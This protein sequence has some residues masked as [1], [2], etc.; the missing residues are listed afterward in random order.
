M[1]RISRPE[2]APAVLASAN[3]KA[4][5]EA[6]K[7][8]FSADPDAYRSGNKTFAGKGETPRF[9][10]KVYG[11]AG[12]RNALKAM[13]SGKCAFCESR[14]DHVSYGD[15][16]HFRPKGAVRQAAD[17][18]LERPGYYWLVYEWSNL[19]ESCQLCNQRFKENRFPLRDPASRAR[20]H[21]QDVALEKPMLVKPD[22]EDPADFLAFEADI[23]RGIDPVGRGETTIDVLQLNRPE[24]VSRR[25]EH[26]ALLYL[27]ARGARKLPPDD[28]VRIETEARVLEMT[29]DQG[30]YA[31]M[32]RA[33]IAAGW[34]QPQT[35]P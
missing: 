11:A 22:I 31:A 13:Q 23:M 10:S 25:R 7:D 33:A 8:A 16:E 1:I 32:V 28:P 29:R 20:D 2:R 4:R 24:L 30:Q 35:T 14:F 34:N 15:V 26:Y 17:G 21:T 18:A 19:F 3:A 12:V 27:L 9:A 6:L 5:T